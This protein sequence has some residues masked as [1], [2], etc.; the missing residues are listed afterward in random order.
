M[1]TI[2]KGRTMKLNKP[3]LRDSQFTNLIDLT[4]RFP[5]EK[6][7]REYLEYM[8]WGGKIKCVHCGS[9]RKIY[10][11]NDGKLFKCANCRKQFTVKVGLIF[12]D[13]AL[14]LQKWFMA[15]YIFMA[16]KKGISS[17]QLGKDIGV[18]QAT[19]WHMLHRLRYAV[20]TRPQN[21]LLGGIIE[22]DETYVGG[23]SHRG[24][25]GRSTNNKTI[26][27]GIKKRGGKIIAQTVKR[28]TKK[29]L[30]GI[31]RKNISPEAVVFTDEWRG[32]ADL[33][34]SFDTHETVNHGSKEYVRDGVIHTNSIESFWALFKRGYIG[35]YHHMSRKH[36]DKYIDEF[37]Y[38]TNTKQLKDPTRFSSMLTRCE[39]RLT[40]K[41]L[42]R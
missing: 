39:G 24:M 33:E 11:F 15:I 22:A 42:I 3:K 5:D 38:R 2:T 37:E 30:Q 29:T 34:S 4:K 16:H 12:E 27:F 14:P 40:Y 35:V 26:V 25:G 9:S 13:S 20:R 19:A 28:A 7:C 31:M 21:P 36:M 18:R 17:V 1:S 32:Y 10:R 6:T 41:N 23:K 8:R